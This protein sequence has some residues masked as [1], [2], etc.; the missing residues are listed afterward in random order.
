MQKADRALASARLLLDAGDTDGACN[1]AYYAMFDAAR[2]ALA[3]EVELETTKTHGGLIAAFGLQLVKPG[4]LP[5][6]LGRMLNRA[7]EVRLLADYTGGSVESAD[8]RELLSQAEDFVDAVRNYLDDGSRGTD[9]T[10]ADH[11]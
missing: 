2:A 7:E 3:N 1:R 9:G 8:A 5:K 4:R 11:A 6:A 10:P